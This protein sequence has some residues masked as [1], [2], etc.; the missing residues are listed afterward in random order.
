MGIID[1]KAVKLSNEW[2]EGWRE[3]ERERRAG[4]DVRG[5]L[6]VKKSSISTVTVATPPVE[7]DERYEDFIIM[8]VKKSLQFWTI[9]DFS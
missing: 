6:E 9:R 2:R 7:R 5:G 3:R 4:G 8:S 1:E